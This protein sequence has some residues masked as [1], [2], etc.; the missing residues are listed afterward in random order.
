MWSKEREMKR[1][2]KRRKREERKKDSRPDH[3]Y[4]RPRNTTSFITDFD[5][6]ILTTLH[7]DHFDRWEL[8]FIIHSESLHYRSQRVFEEFETDM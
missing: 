6:D 5:G 8:I 2:G 7:N 3:R 1:K 4:G